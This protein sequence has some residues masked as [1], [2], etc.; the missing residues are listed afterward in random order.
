[1]GVAGAT[2]HTAVVSSW[3]WRQGPERNKKGR[4]EECCFL[5]NYI[6][7]DTVKT[8][9]TVLEDDH[10]FF[11][12]DQFGKVDTY[13]EIR[14]HFSLQWFLFLSFLLVQT[15][16]PGDWKQFPLTETEIS[17]IKASSRGGPIPLVN[18]QN[19]SCLLSPGAGGGPCTWR[20]RRQCRQVPTRSTA[21]VFRPWCRDQG[22]GDQG[23]GRCSE[24]GEK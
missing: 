16:I 7:S 18:S 17:L 11:Q 9:H 22:G 24:V 14:M 6:I 23:L 12:F 19:Q 5:R 21:P 15:E 8:F 20:T 2:V 13:I 10:K 1:M 3:C 4:G